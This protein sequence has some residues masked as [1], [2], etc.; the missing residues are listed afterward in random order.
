MAEPT[1]RSE[2]LFNAVLHP[3]R[4][5]SAR[6]F[7]WLMGIVSCVA[8]TVGGVFFFAGAWPIFGFFGLDILLIYLF[9]RANYRSGQVYERVRLTDQALE[10]ERGDHRGRH[11][12]ESLPPHWLQV[13]MD[14]P[15]RHES[16]V[17][18]ASHGRTLV[19]GAFLTP[20]E[21]LDFDHALKDALHRLRNPVYDNPQLDGHPA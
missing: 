14:D 5:L 16:Q 6:G 7:A 11:S 19:V 10:V 20:E 15:P 9:F 1:K 12:L 3:H 4:S 21:R 13:L 2:T 8:L 18:L 17:R